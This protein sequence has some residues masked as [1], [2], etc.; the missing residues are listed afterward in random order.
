MDVH[1]DMFRNNLGCQKLYC[2]LA[3]ALLEG[4]PARSGSHLHSRRSEGPPGHSLNLS[5]ETP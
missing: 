5:P 3:L 2:E 1:L 4:A